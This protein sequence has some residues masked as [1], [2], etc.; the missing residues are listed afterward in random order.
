MKDMKP[1]VEGAAL[2]DGNPGATTVTGTLLEV[3]EVVEA[4]G[5]PEGWPEGLYERIQL[6]L[7][8]AGA[9]R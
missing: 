3:Y 2:H 5:E 8:G 9:L 4:Q 6:A 1:V 7:R